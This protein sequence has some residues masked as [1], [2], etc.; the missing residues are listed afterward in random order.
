MKKLSLQ[1]L[2]RISVDEFK[3]AKKIPVVIILDNIRSLSNIGSFFRTADAL[4]IEKIFLVGI[5]AQPP[6][7]EIRKTALGATESVDWE[8]CESIEV[9]LRNLKSSYE[10]IAIEQTNESILLQEMEISK[11]KRYA[12]IFGN[13]VNGISEAVI[14]YLDCAIEIPQFGTKHSF[15]VAISGGIVMWEFAKKL[16][17]KNE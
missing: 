14:P 9:L 10:I 6:H 4:L 13:E 7:R 12:L 11:R 1:E 5:T 8:Y 15:N 2:N 16:L 3:E 17:L